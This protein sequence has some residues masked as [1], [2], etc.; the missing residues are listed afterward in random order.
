MTNAQEITAYAVAHVI[1]FVISA[2]L[3]TFVMVPI[4]TSTGIG[5]HAGGR[6]LVA[7]VFFV[8]VQIVV[9]GAFIA[10]RG[11]PRVT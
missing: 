1:G 4:Y 6:Y 3:T 7:F 8:V 5:A 10:M 9:F 2:V 11:R